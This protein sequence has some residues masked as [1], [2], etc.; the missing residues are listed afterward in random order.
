MIAVGSGGLWGKGVGYG[1]Q[2]RLHFLPE[3]QTDFIFAA[4]A[5]EWGFIG[6]LFMF[7]WLGV[8]FWRIIRIL[9][10]APDDFSK[11]FGIGFIF[12]LLGHIAI[13]VGM[14]VGLLPITGIS[15]PFV[16]YGGSFLLTLMAGIG[17]LESINVRTSI[18]K[19]HPEDS[20]VL[21]SP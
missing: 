15:L 13:H 7:S 3:S 16:S 20:V 18:L 6:V 1:T 10:R 21:L 8:L 11:L 17:L 19:A 2:S 4:F 14:S 12:L 5:E 9:A